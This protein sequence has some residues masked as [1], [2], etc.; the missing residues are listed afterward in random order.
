VISH[1]AAAIDLVYLEAVLLEKFVA[2]DDDG[3][4]RVAPQRQHRRMFEQQ[5]R[6]AN[7]ILHPCRNHP[8]L[9]VETFRISNAAEMEEVDKHLLQQFAELLDG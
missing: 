9:E 2:D 8:L 7:E 4:M 5:Q 6:D 1:V 3:A